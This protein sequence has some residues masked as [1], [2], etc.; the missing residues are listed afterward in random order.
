ME[1]SSISVWLLFVIVAGCEYTIKQWCEGWPPFQRG[2]TGKG[3]MSFRALHAI[4]L[5][6][7]VLLIFP[8]SLS[9]ILFGPVMA[10]VATTE[11]LLAWI[12]GR[13]F[14]RTGVRLRWLQL[15]PMVLLFAL[16]LWTG[17]GL[18][19]QPRPWIY[20]ILAAIPQRLSMDSSIITSAMPTV[21]AFIGV[22][23]FL[24]HPANY[25]VRAL[26]DKE[27]DRFLP[28]MVTF[29]P[30]AHEPAPM[31]RADSHHPRETLSPIASAAGD[32]ASELAPTME[33]PEYLDQPGVTTTPV[34][35]A[36]TKDT[37]P[38]ESLRAGRI[39][40]ILE[41]WLIVTLV[42]LSQYGPLG[43][44]LT[45]KSVARLKQLDDATFA[46]YYLLGTL[47]SMVLAIAGGL[48]LQTFVF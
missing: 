48:F 17:S 43:L 25:V 34:R 28:E 44:V 37:P 39:I 8:I 2:L 27:S 18:I 32:A 14:I 21:L 7:C 40:G 29:L 9:T 11:L 15:V 13:V 42:V 22:Y 46:E 16:C 3:Y 30:V 47:Y 38:W 1:S 24:A 4:V 12:Q 45:A 23:T 35:T 26:V 6:L 20:F 41:R 33:E 31:A 36:A 19:V 5:S 10:L